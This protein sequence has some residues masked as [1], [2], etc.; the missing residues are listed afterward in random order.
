MRH[1]LLTIQW[2]LYHKATLFVDR[3]WPYKGGQPLERGTFYTRNKKQMQQLLAI[4]EGAAAV[5]RCLIIEGPL[6]S[7]EM[8]ILAN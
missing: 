8:N 2:S 4:L 6:D 5:A 7:L 1:T 3:F